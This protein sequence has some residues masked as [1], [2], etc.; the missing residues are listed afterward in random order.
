MQTGTVTGQEITENRNG[1]VDV[2]MLQ[3]NLNTPER[4]DNQAIQYV[5]M[6]GDDSPPQNGDTVFVLSIGQ[7]F[8]VAIGVQDSVIPSMLAGEKKSY[9]RDSA[10]DI[11]AFIN[12]LGGGN[13]ELNGNAF[14]AVRFA[15]LET[16][17]NQF[18]SDYNAHNHG[19]SGTNTPT[20]ADIS[21]A[22]SE[23]VKL[24]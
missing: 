14:T 21:P 13:L 15:A 2:R 1:G 11:A 18:K 10:G 19:G 17:F 8:K 4:P 12:Y 7:S 3:V 24:K 9:S 23:T 22:E 16:A 20:S 6:S 5:P